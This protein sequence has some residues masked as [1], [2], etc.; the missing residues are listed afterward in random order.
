MLEKIQWQG[1]ILALILRRELNVDGVKFFT[2]ADNPL[3]LGILQ[4]RQGTEIKPHLHPDSVRTINM[5]Q[6]VLY[7]ERGRVKADFYNKDG[8]NISSS[9]LNTGDAILLLSGGHGFKILE[10]AK[11]LEIKQG[12][13]CGVDRDKERIDRK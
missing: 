12:P 9:I 6:E 4:H 3:Q 10:D 7:I 13:Y 8:E 5:T 11:I 1:Q 2:S